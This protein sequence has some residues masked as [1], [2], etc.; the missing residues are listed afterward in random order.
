MNILERA[1][2]LCK[3]KGHHSKQKIY[4][5]IDDV[6]L[7]TAEAM[8]ELINNKYRIPNNLQPRTREQCK[9]W[10]FKGLWR[11]LTKEQQMELFESD[12]FWDTV[13]IKPEFYNIVKSGVLNNYE[14]VFV[15]KGSVYN[16]FKKKEFLYEEVDIKDA[17]KDFSFIGIADDEDKASIDMTDGIQID[18]NYSNL[19]NTKAKIKILVK[20]YVESTVNNSYGMIDTPDNLY[21]VNSLTEVLDILKFNL[22]ET[23]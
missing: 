1:V 19:K 17:F 7:N 10:D 11:P 8:A 21:N 12:E 6:V 15:T 5:D 9:D 22:I 18:D 4:W 3:K 16:L 14:N 20:N 13:I 2:Q 23:L